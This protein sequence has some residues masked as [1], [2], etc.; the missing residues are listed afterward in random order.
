[1][2]S[3]KRQKAIRKRNIFLCCCAVLIIAAV[4]A[5]TFAVSIISKSIK[6]SPSG[7]SSSASSQQAKKPD[8]NAVVAT[9]TVVNTGDLLLHNPLL[10][11]AKKADGTYDFSAFFPNIKKYFTDADYAVANLEVTLGG[12]ESGE[13]KGYPNF[14]V[15]DNFIDEC[16]NSGIDLFLTANNHCYD[17]GLYGLKRTVKVLKEKNAEFLG[18]K[19]QESD[20]TYIVKDINGIKIGMIC[21]TYENKCD[22]AG[23]KSINGALISTEA[24]PLINSFSYQNLDGFYQNA[25]NA[26]ASMK[27]DGAECIVFYMHWGDEYRLKQNDYQKNIAQKLCDIGADVIVG[28]HPHVVQPIEML[29]SSDSSRQTVCLYS[30]GNAISNQRLEELSAECPGGQTEDGVLFYYTFTKYG[31]GRVKLTA[32][33]IIPTWVKKTGERYKA[34]YTVYPLESEQAIESLGLDSKTL[35][36]AKKSYNRTKTTVSAGLS[37]CQQKLGC[38]KRFE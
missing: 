25:E 38:K 35:D 7:A 4:A 15:P 21:Y 22:V 11:G 19:E 33:D 12:K 8:K 18:T 34:Q 26:V 32:T 16:K 5:V 10:N 1:M 14:N 17:T 2:G 29:T 24:N 31:D 9:A 30:M 3:T 37:D 6:S 20:H 28:G 23:R 36:S 27:N 13:Y